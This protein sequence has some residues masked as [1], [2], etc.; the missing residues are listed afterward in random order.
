MH[1][2]IPLYP[3]LSI[4]QSAKLTK[5]RVIKERV[6]K[7]LKSQTGVFHVLPN[8][9][10]YY[11]DRDRTNQLAYFTGTEIR[12]KEDKFLTTQQIN[13]FKFQYLLADNQREWSLYKFQYHT[14]TDKVNG[15]SIKRGILELVPYDSSDGQFFKVNYLD[16]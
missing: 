1:H 10:F 2:N 14:F 15:A 13:S 12:V 9:R 7:N 16:F 11:I 3:L 5:D 6:F 8:E 4:K